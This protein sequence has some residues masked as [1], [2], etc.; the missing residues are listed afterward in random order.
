MK[1]FIAAIDNYNDIVTILSIGNNP[2]ELSEDDD[3]YDYVEGDIYMGKSLVDDEPSDILDM[4]ERN[5]D[6]VK[7]EETKT[8]EFSETS[9]VRV[10]DSDL[11]ALF[12]VN[13]EIRIIIKDIT[14]YIAY[15]VS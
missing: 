10:I 11:D 12:K 1:Y 5:T 7:D 15:I 4:L 8:S 14:Y 6:D 13:K 9:Y 3:F 2:I